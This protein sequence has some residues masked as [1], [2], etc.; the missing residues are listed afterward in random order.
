MA[1]TG[2]L[3]YLI[4]R[5][6]GMGQPGQAAGGGL[7]KQALASGLGKLPGDIFIQ[8]GHFSFYFPVVTCI[9]LSLILTFVLNLFKK[10]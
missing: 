4:G 6:P 2:A 10:P 5:I 9:L 1:G 7:V 3:L 8:K